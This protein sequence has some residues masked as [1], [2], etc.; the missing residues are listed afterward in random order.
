MAGLVAAIRVSATRARKD[1][2]ARRKAG[3]DGGNAVRAPHAYKKSSVAVSLITALSVSWRP[4]RS[5]SASVRV[6]C[7]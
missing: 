4:A 7:K 2:D 3:H 1:V 6:A 5:C